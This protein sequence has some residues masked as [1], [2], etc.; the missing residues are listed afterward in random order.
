MICGVLFD[1][2]GVLVDS[3]AA[4]H[5]SWRVLARRHGRDISDAEFRSAFGC[6]SREIIRLLW[7]AGLSDAEVQRRDTEKESAYRDLIRGHV[8]LMRSCRE[9]LAEL[10][11]AGLQL[12][13]A[14]S[15][16]PENLELVL[17]EAD[18]AAYFAATV[19][20]RDIARGKPA[21][22]CFLLAARRLGLPPA[23]CVVIED[24]PVGIEAGRAAGMPVIALVGTYPPE[25]LLAA[26]ATCVV[27]ALRE[28]APEMLKTVGT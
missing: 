18:L 20:G 19:N 9:T 3:G 28:I 24:A 25:R 10:Q 1:M 17:R 11:K 8:P 14:T 12:A 27:H 7:G 4:H 23:A 5:E 13:V 6:T 26:G 22:D 21:P 16:P 2:D 15:G